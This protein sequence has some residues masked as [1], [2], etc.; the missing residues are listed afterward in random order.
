MTVE[1]ELFDL[2]VIMHFVTSVELDHAHHLVV[3]VAMRY[4][5]LYAG[6]APNC[7]DCFDLSIIKQ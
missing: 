4:L 3:N 1:N 6:K 5:K 2:I 7:I